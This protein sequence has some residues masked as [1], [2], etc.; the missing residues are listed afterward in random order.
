MS[1]KLTEE[2]L[3]RFIKTRQNYFDLRDQIADITISEE[4]IKQQKSKALYD[5][6]VAY[7]S[8]TAIH[9]EI[10][11]KYGDGKVNLQTGEVNS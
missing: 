7:D 3:D 9:K 4:R 8:L 1:N 11:D 10:Q 2:E 6:E 5:I